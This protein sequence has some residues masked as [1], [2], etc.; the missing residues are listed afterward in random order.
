[1]LVVLL[2]LEVSVL[3]LLLGYLRYGAQCIVNGFGVGKEF[4]YIRVEQD[5]VAPL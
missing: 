3:D 2:G 1:M 4:C 5:Q